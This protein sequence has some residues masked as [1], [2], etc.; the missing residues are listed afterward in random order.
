MVGYRE[1]EA[2]AM[3]LRNCPDDIDNADHSGPSCRSG[4]S[5]STGNSTNNSDATTRRHTLREEA[6]KNI[7]LV[8]KNDNLANKLADSEQKVTAMAA[9]NQLLQEQLAAFCN[10]PV[11]TVPQDDPIVIPPATLTADKEMEEAKGLL[12]LRGGGGYGS[13]SCDHDEEGPCGGSLS[14]DHI[15]PTFGVAGWYQDDGPLQGNHPPTGFGQGSVSQFLSPTQL[16]TASAV[17]GGH[18]S[19]VHGGIHFGHYRST[20]PG[21]HPSAHRAAELS[22]CGGGIPHP[23]IIGV[24]Q[25]SSVS[26]SQFLSLAQATVAAPANHAAS[27]L[28][29]PAP[30]NP[31]TDPLQM[32]GGSLLASGEVCQ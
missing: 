15:F 20:P 6:L 29:L 24:C 28:S 3:T 4:F 30:S 9:Q 14:A 7:A 17:L 19:S 26:P 13:L 23:P 31:A 11:Q 2:L 8:N 16:G 27:G 5:Q 32:D 1:A 10:G 22:A 12:P 25:G 21:S 18:L